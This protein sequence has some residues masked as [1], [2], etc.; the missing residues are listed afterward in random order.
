M[1]GPVNE[2]RKVTE[3]ITCHGNERGLEKCSIAYTSPYRDIC[4]LT[5]SI[6]SITC[7]HDSFAECEDAYDVPWGEKCYSLLPK[8]STFEEGQTWCKQHGKTL[9]EIDTQQENNLLSELLLT[10]RYSG[11]KFSE[12]W[13]GGKAVKSPRRSNRFYWDGSL[14]DIGNIL[15][16][17]RIFNC[18]TIIKKFYL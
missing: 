3:D 4:E 8:R 12:V 5:S 15:D 7:L 6:V 16:H 9:V 10:H 14:T 1:N 13:V 11:G 17:N 18:I 2:E